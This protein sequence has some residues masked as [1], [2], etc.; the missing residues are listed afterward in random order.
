MKKIATRL[1]RLMNGVYL[2]IVILACCVYFIKRDIDVEISIMAVLFAGVPLLAT[3]LISISLPQSLFPQSFLFIGSTVYVVHFFAYFQHCDEY[4]FGMMFALFLCIYSMP[5]FFMIW[6]I[7]ILASPFE[8]TD[9][10]SKN[11]EKYS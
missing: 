2:C 5:I 3:L 11:N 8:I 7:S 1:F 4:T 6:I 9:N 10:C